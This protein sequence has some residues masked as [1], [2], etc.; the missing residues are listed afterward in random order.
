M[1]GLRGVFSF[2]VTINEAT[3]QKKPTQ[4][5]PI[6]NN[7]QRSSCTPRGNLFIRRNGGPC[8]AKPLGSE[9]QQAAPPRSLFRRPP[10]C[11]TR[12]S[13]E[14]HHLPHGQHEIYH[15]LRDEPHT[16]TSLNA[17]G[18]FGLWYQVYAD[19]AVLITFSN[20]TFCP[21]ATYGPLFPDGTF[22]VCATGSDSTTTRKIHG[23]ASQ[24][25]RARSIVG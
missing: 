14:P 25:C 13:S 10:S 6:C 19:L 16:V 23:F 2:P 15:E 9:R 22:G 20:N 4:D 3:R 24:R 1:N 7:A 5:Y 12:S 17:T 8:G 21:T 11:T 18:F